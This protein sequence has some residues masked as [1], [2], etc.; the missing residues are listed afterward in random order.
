MEIVLRPIT[1]TL[2][3][4]H[5][6]GVTHR[7]TRPWSILLSEPMTVEEALTKTDGYWEPHDKQKTR[8]EFEVAASDLTVADFTLTYMAGTV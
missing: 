6:F 1:F 5:R 4:Q 7:D 2:F 8:L 3:T